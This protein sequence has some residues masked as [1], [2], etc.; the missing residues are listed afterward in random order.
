MVGADLATAI[1]LDTILHD[2]AAAADIHVN[3]A[4]QH[5]G[6]EQL[7]HHRDT[8]KLARPPIPRPSE[9]FPGLQQLPE[10]CTLQRR[11]VE[12]AGVGIALFPPDF[13]RGRVEVR[14]DAERP[15][16]VG[17]K[18]LDNTTAERRVLVRNAAS[19]TGRAP[20]Q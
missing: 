9:H 12:P 1:V 13:P 6:S 16:R 17:Y 10:R 15:D 11:E 14:T 7:D 18:L 3:G 5:F 20:R 2:A 4:V 19:S 8:G